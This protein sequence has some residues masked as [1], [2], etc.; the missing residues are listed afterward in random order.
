LNELDVRKPFEVFISQRRE[1]L[2]FYNLV[3]NLTIPNPVLKAVS[4][5]A[6]PG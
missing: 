6:S 4:S 2:R 1:E 5:N 3:Y